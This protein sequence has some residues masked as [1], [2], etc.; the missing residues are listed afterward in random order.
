MPKCRTIYSINRSENILYDLIID[1]EK[2]SAY[3]QFEMFQESLDVLDSCL[4]SK[5]L[6]YESLKSALLPPG[7]DKNEVVFVFDNELQDIKTNYILDSFECIVSLLKGYRDSSMSLKSGD[8]IY[9]PR[10]SEF[11]F[12]LLKKHLHDSS[13]IICPE[14]RRYYAI[15]FNSLSDEMINNIDR[16]FQRLSH[17]VGYSKISELSVF[18]SIIA[19]SLPTMT[20]LCR[21]HAIFPEAEDVPGSTNSFCYDCL[22]DHFETVLIPELLYGSFLSFKMDS[23]I[24]DN[25]TTE[26]LFVA[27]YPTNVK[28]SNLKLDLDT[29]KLQYLRKEKPHLSEIFGPDYDLN[30]IETFVKSLDYNHVYNVRYCPDQNPNIIKFNVVTS[31]FDSDRIP[32]K[33]I[34]ALKIDIITNVVGLVTVY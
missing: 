5:G 22:K 23:L 4:K 34:V 3:E 16:I 33:V 17:Y 26:L 31:Y 9:E 15:Y 1:E 25:R 13:R 20:V 27:A 10:Y 14:Y 11:I 6:S 24:R 28:L 19:N 7:K 18:K 8:I 2:L 29:S 32:H 21:G 30:T 12:E